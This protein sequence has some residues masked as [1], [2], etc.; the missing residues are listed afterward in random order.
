MQRGV[1]GHVKVER[2]KQP[3][4]T[5]TYTTHHRSS[6]TRAP[7]LFHTCLFFTQYATVLSHTIYHSLFFVTETSLSSQYYHLTLC[8]LLDIITSNINLVQA[9]TSNVNF[10]HKIYS[11]LNY[12]LL[13]LPPMIFR[14]HPTK[15]LKCPYLWLVLRKFPETL[16]NYNISGLSHKCRKNIILKNYLFFLHSWLK[17]QKSILIIS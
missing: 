6:P 3:G 14:A 9:K 12:G 5:L 7:T 11:N 2:R 17:S 16:Y 8:F 1:C 4:D 15:W 13:L 10:I